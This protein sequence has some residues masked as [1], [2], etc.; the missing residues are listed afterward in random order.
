MS[1]VVNHLTKKFGLQKA[2]DE[3]SFQ[4]NP[5]EIVGLLGPNGAGKT[6]T[7][8]I[9]SGYY[10]EYEGEALVNDVSISEN[11]VF[12]KRN[13]GYLS[14]HNPLYLEMF[15]KEYLQFVAS[16]FKLKNTGS[17]VKSLIKLTGLEREQHKKIKSLSKGYRQRVGLAQAIMH[18]P[19][20]LILDEPTTG[21][22]PN[23][24]VEIRGLIR[25]FGQ[26][27]TIIFSSHIMQEV[28]A[29][30][31][32]VIILDNGKLVADEKVAHLDALMR[33]HIEIMVEFNQPIQVQ[34]VKIDNLVAVDSIGNNKYRFR[35]TKGTDP[36]PKLFDHAVANQIK[37]HEMIQAKSSVEDIFQRLT[38]K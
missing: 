13:T 38:K 20:V 5:G 7:M 24:L 29:I 28:Q 26:D 22:D 9:L 17:R 10:Q 16:V 3:V 18:D 23:Q 1:I 6:T 19:D 2:I 12:V 36:R 32:R 25:S 30:C 4:V 37:I 8:K 33:D 35:F 11:P 21:L 34:K 15:V 27:K 14:E 31:D